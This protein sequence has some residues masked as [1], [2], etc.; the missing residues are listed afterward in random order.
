MSV[1]LSSSSWLFKKQYFAGQ[2]P[3]F[4]GKWSTAIS[5]KT[6]VEKAAIYIKLC[7]NS[8]QAYL[9]YLQTFPNIEYLHNIYIL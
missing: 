9:I 4:V 2:C 7:I 8:K 6:V 3:H 1:L 5:T